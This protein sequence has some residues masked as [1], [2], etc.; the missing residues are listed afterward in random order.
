MLWQRYA[1]PLQQATPA[2]PY[3]AQGP[4]PSLR[5]RPPRRLAC[6][7]S[8]AS[9]LFYLVCI[10][11]PNCHP[12]PPLFLLY[13][14]SSSFSFLPFILLGILVL[15]FDIF[16]L[17]PVNLFTSSLVSKGVLL[18]TRLPER[19]HRLPLLPPCRHRFPSTSRAFGSIRLLL[20]NYFNTFISVRPARIIA[21]LSFCSFV[22]SLL[23]HPGTN[24]GTRH[25]GSPTSIHLVTPSPASDCLARLVMPIASPRY[26]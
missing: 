6:C 5:T 3:R 17:L 14:S 9:S 24:N 8:A 19:Q 25:H 15:R 2:Y 12:F 1:L 23:R 7:S 10:P 11:F 16:G 4:I 26:T 20:S 21:L 22:N 13:P 18:S